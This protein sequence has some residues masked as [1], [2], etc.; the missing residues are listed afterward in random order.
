M[1]YVSPACH[2]RHHR[3]C[4]SSDF[5]GNPHVYAG[6]VF[7]TPDMPVLRH[8]F[9]HNSHTMPSSDCQKPLAQ[10]FFVCIHWI[11]RHIFHR[12]F[13]L[14]L[15]HPEAF[16]R[17]RCKTPWQS[18]KIFLSGRGQ[19][20]GLPRPQP[21]FLKPPGIYIHFWL[22][23]SNICWEYLDELVLFLHVL[24]SLHNICADMR[25]MTLRY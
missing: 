11:I 9:S 23:V 20:Q 19:H 12:F 22:Y 3:I 14:P 4:T 21:D 10:L 18:D 25:F 13:N 16:L 1:P 15:R 2:I 17:I 8:C 5:M 7:H 6:N 24:T